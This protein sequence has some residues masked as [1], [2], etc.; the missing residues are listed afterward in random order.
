MPSITINIMAVIA[1]A[2]AGHL[3]GAVWFSQK[4][5][6]KAWME[7][8]GQHPKPQDAHPKMGKLLAMSFLGTLVTS[9]I[10]AHF[11]DYVAATDASG[12]L[13]LAFWTWLGFFATSTLGSVL[14]DCKKSSW[15]LVMNGYY[16]VQ[17][18]IMSLILALWV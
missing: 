18:S 13:S 17:L 2:M 9:Y 14:W 10:L 1:A 7:G 4:A 6:G 12:A 15:W 8:S 11:V 16:F 3:L 5:F